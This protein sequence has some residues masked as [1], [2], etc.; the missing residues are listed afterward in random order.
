MQQK[1]T[2]SRRLTTKPE[3]TDDTRQMAMIIAMAVRNAMEDFH[4]Q[5]L[6]DAQMRDLNPIIRNA[7]CTALHALKNYSKSAKAREFINFSA[8]LIP[9]YWEKPELIAPFGDDTPPASGTRIK[10][11]WRG[12]VI[13]PSVYQLKVTLKYSKPPIWRRVQVLSD[14][15]LFRLHQILQMVMGWTNSHLHQ[16]IVRGAYYSLPDPEFGT[17]QDER[18]VKLGE[19]VSAPKRRFTYEY[20]FGDSWL[21][22]ILVEKIA[23]PEPGVKYPV[24]LAGQRSCPPE[25]CG[26]VGGYGEFL[27]AIRDPVHPEHESMLEWIGGSFDPEAFDVDKI[28]RQLKRRS[29]NDPQAAESRR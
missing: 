15:T 16:F 25:D 1:K 28:N 6:S 20:D 2:R 21:H 18:K 17:A 9:N 7:I 11:S 5:H 3:L 10:P 23:S 12:I 22:E 29:W 13:S 19:I 8:L 26:G 27:K 14:T 24:C 4:C